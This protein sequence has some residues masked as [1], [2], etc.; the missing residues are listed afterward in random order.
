[1][2]TCGWR[3]VT[4]VAGPPLSEVESIPSFQVA[5]CSQKH[6]YYDVCMEESLNSPLFI[7]LQIFVGG[8]SHAHMLTFHSLPS[9]FFR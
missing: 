4:L 1:M 5:G 9:W 3:K 8:Y 6:V 7:G 2:K